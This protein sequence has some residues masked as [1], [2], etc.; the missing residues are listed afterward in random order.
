MRDQIIK[1]LASYGVFDQAH[2]HEQDAYR[3]VIADEIL[4]L[5]S[6]GQPI[7]INVEPGKDVYLYFKDPEVI[8][9]Y[10]TN[11]IVPDEIT[12]ERRDA[13]EP[14]DH[15]PIHYCICEKCKADRYPEGSILKEAYDALDCLD[16]IEHY[17]ALE[18][19][20]HD[21]EQSRKEQL[22]HVGRVFATREDRVG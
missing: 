12:P 9:R 22:V 16:S 10:Y 14:D 18:K 15:D 6:V 20:H 19:V 8:E 5:G 17:R 7:P 13:G 21:N 3:G 2:L 1:I 11:P 4:A